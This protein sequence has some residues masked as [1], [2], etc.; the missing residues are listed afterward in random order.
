MNETYSRENQI[1]E[2][3]TMIRDSGNTCAT[4]LYAIQSKKTSLLLNYKNKVFYTTRKSAREARRM[5][6]QHQTYLPKDVRIVTTDFVN[7]YPWKTA[8]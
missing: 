1:Q 5:I 2:L 3:A 4:H 6:L 7:V 8:K